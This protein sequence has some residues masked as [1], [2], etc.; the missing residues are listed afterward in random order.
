MKEARYKLISILLVLCITFTSLSEVLA[1]SA[2]GAPW[3]QEKGKYYGKQLAQKDKVKTING[4]SSKTSKPIRKPISKDRKPAFEFSFKGKQEVKEKRT[5]NSKTFKEDN[6]KLKTYVYLD[7][8]HYKDSSGKYQDID[9]TLVQQGKDD[10]AAYENKAN[11]YKV[12]FPSKITKNNSI[13][14]T[15]EDNSIQ[16]TPTEGDFS[17]S[18]VNGSSILYQDAF[19]GIDFQYDVNNSSV[20]EN[21]T[22]N[23]F[24]DKN[25]FKYEIEAKNLSLKEELGSI[26]AYKSGQKAP[27]FIINAP[28]MIDASGKK[29]SALKIHLNKKLIGKDIIEVEADKNWL[30]D[31][32][33]AYPVVID[34]DVSVPDSDIHTACTEQATPD[35]NTLDNGFLYV[36][37]DDGIATYNGVYGHLKTRTYIKFPLNADSTTKITSANLILDKYTSYSSEARSIGLY[38][39]DDDNFSIYEV[40][41]N[42]QPTAKSHYSSTTVDGTIKPAVFDVTNLLNDWINGSKHNNGIVLQY[43]DETKQCEVFAGMN[44]EFDSTLPHLEIESQIVDPVDPNMALGAPTI[45]VRPITEHNNDG[46]LKLD[47]VFADGVEKPGATVTYQSNPD[48]MKFNG[49]VNADKSYKYPDST[50]LQS[51]Y[52][53]GYVFKGKDSNWQTDKAVL[54][55][56]NKLYT[57]TATAQLDGKTT[58]VANSDSFQVYQVQAKDIFSSIANYYGVDLN[59]LLNDNKAEDGLLVEENT[60]FIR[61]PKNNGGKAYTQSQLTDEMKKQ[62]DSYLVGRK[63]HCIYGGEPINLISGN[64]YYNSDDVTVPDLGGNFTIS[65]SYNSMEDYHDGLFGVKWD[66]NFNK[67]LSQLKDGTIILNTGDGSAVYFTKNSDGSY[68]APAGVNDQLSKVSSTDGTSYQIIENEKITYKFYKNGLLKSITDIKGNVTQLGY[69]ENHKLTSITTPSEKQFVIKCDDQGRIA[70]IIQPNGAALSYGYD[71]KGNLTSFIDASGRETNYTYDDNNRMVSFNDGNHNQVISNT[72]DDQGRVLK[73][74]DANGSTV[75]I[76]YLDGYN[77][78]VDGNGN[79]TLYYYDS[80]YRTTKVVRPDKKTEESTYDDNDNLT[81]FKDAKDRITKYEYDERGNKLRETR[82]DEKS[83]AYTYDNQ[84]NLLSYT[85]FNGKTT[86]MT[87]DSVGNLIKV[88]NPDGAAV[89]YT[90]NSKN[91]VETMKDYQNNI[92]KYEYTGADITTVTEPNGD[93]YKYHYNSMG[94]VVTIEDPLNKISRI[95]YNPSGD[96]IN[97]QLPDNSVKEYDYDNNGNNKSMT[98]GNNNTISFQY[99]KLNKL[100]KAIDPLGYETKFIYDANG[101]KVVESN[102]RGYSKKYKYNNLNSLVGIT[103]EDNGTT[104]YVRDELGNITSV[105]DANGNKTTIVYNYNVN[106]P[107]SITNQL[108]QVITNIYDNEG[109]TLKT[110][111]PDGTYKQYSYD[112][113]YRLTKFKDAN[114]IERTITYGTKNKITKITDSTGK[115]YEY[116]YDGNGNLLKT[117]DPLGYNISYTYN[118]G[119]LMTS[120]TNEEGKTINYNYD[121]VGRISQIINPLG[122]KKSFN[123]DLNGNIATVTDG[124][125]YSTKYYYDQMNRLKAVK[126]ALEDIT[127]YN[128]D[129]V[130][131]IQQ[132][133]DALGNTTKYEYNGRNLTTKKTDALN[134]ITQ[135]IYD[136]DGNNIQ[137][138]DPKGSSYNFSYDGANRLTAV[139]DAAGLKKTTSYDNMNRV[140]KETDNAGNSIENSYDSYGRLTQQKDII[141]RT[142]K[143]E[144]DSSGNIV[145]KI[146]ID[147]NTTSYKYDA[148]NR[149][150]QV[151]DPEGKVTNFKYNG[152][153]KIVSRVEP[154][155]KAYSFEYDAGGNIVKATDPV[156]AATTFQYDGNNNLIEE[157]NAKGFSKKYKYDPIG[158]LNAISDENGNKTE[159]S[160]DGDRNVIKKV[161]PMGN[162]TQYL[163]DALNRLQTEVDALGFGKEYGY[164]KLGNMISFTDA[165]GNQTKYE[166]NNHNKVIK[167]TDALS[168]ITQYQYNLNDNILSKTDAIGAQYKYGYDAVHRLTT[169]TD[170]NGYIVN[171]NYDNLGNIDK[172]YDSAGN[173]K[174]FT[175]DKMHRLLTEKDTAGHMTT[176]NYDTYGNI[177][178]VKQPNGNVTNYEHDILNRLT[179]IVDPEGKTTQINYDILGNTEKVTNPGDQVYQYNYDPAN[180]LQS[181]TNPLGETT[182]YGYNKN[183][184]LESV[185]NPLGNTT[186]YSYNEINKLKEIKNPLGYTTIYGYDE[187][188]NLASV[189][190]G[191]GQRSNYNYDKLNRLS[192]VTNALGNATNYSYD[193][194]GNL[195]N[196]TDG[197]GHKTQYTYDKR[198]AL[199]SIKNPLEQTESFTYNDIGNVTS[200]T[201][202]DGTV[203]NYSYDNLNRL[204][205]TDTYNEDSESA[206]SSSDS[207]DSSD[208][209][210]DYSYDIMGNRT[211]MEGAEGVT[212]YTYDFMERLTNVNSPT[213]EEVKYEYDSLGRKSKLIYPDGKYVSYSYDNLNRLVSAV[214]WEGKKTTYTYDAG[215]RRIETDLPN[216]DKVKY[217]Y[218]EAD[219]LIKQENISKDGKTLSSFDYAYDKAG[220][221]VKEVQHDPDNDDIFT[222]TY[223]YDGA[224]EVIGFTEQEGTEEE[225]KYDYAYDKAGNRIA[226]QIKDDDDSKKITY[227]YDSA[228]QLITELDGDKNIKYEY[229]KNGNRIKKIF[230]GNHVEYYDYDLEGRLS[231]ITHVSGSIETFGYDGDGNRLF[232]TIGYYLEPPANGDGSTNGVESETNKGEKG[233]GSGSDSGN[234]KDKGNHNG[235]NSGKNS[236]KSSLLGNPRLAE[237]QQIK[238]LLAEVK[239]EADS[240]SESYI[241]SSSIRNPKL[242]EQQRIKD[243]IAASKSG[244]GGG[245]HSS[246]GGSNSH[247]GGNSGKS[248]KGNG[249]NG[250]GS[251]QDN[252]NG[253]D[254]GNHYG[255]NKK[256]TKKIRGGNGK[257]LGWYKRAQKPKLHGKSPIVTNDGTYEVVNYLNDVSLANPEVLMTSDE[258]KVYQSA[259]TYGLDRISVRYLAGNNDPKYTPLYYHYNGR[260]DVTSLVNTADNTKAK[261]RY[262]AFGV[263]KPGVKL[264]IDSNG[265]IN[266]YGYNSEDYDMY[267]GIQYLRARY[268]EP[269]TGRFLTRDSYLG[270]IMN[271]LTL[272]RYAYVGNNP[273][274][275]TDP[276]GNMFEWLFSK[277]DTSGYGYVDWKAGYSGP[278]FESTSEPESETRSYDTPIIYGY[279]DWKAGGSGLVFESTSEPESETQSYDTSITSSY[280]YSNEGTYQSE[281]NNNQSFIDIV[282]ERRK[283]WEKECG[284]FSYMNSSE[285]T[286]NADT[287]GSQGPSNSTIIFPKNAYPGYYDV[288]TRYDPVIEMYKD[289]D[290]VS[291]AIFQ[292]PFGDVINAITIERGGAFVQAVQKL[293]MAEEEAAIIT[294]EVGITSKEA[295]NLLPEGVGAQKNHNIDPDSYT[296]GTYDEGVSN[297]K[298]K[299]WH[300]NYVDN[301]SETQ[302]ILGVENVDKG[303][304]TIGSATESV[305]TNTGKAWVGEGYKAITDNAGNVIGYSSSDGMR[306]FRIQY[307]PKE[308]MWRANF[309][310]NYKYINE[311]GATKIKELKNVHIDILD[312]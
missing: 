196:F 288:S 69:D 3:K 145:S 30:S 46:L 134:N 51:T 61:N 307:K 198:G 83:R 67:Y 228:D 245:G 122:N 202:P 238:G 9:N 243:Y 35:I 188:R 296:I 305:A 73:Q 41:W 167:I 250:N 285:G 264:D 208:D 289:A 173:V 265:F 295:G 114:G 24:T 302:T 199:T 312:K 204:V 88:V 155:E 212:D 84:N 172:Q 239:F 40:N 156:N 13:Q 106:K 72:Y 71:D 249:R 7:K 92:T 147:G 164:D 16:L 244:G 93:T 28:V 121:D 263:P 161:D 232:R 304:A 159:F 148:R 132:K 219:Q 213:D 200:D 236:K 269:G 203:T 282:N 303:L 80:Q 20:K 220:N 171:F 85:D 66:F 105:T 258:N 60:I 18:A 297:P 115:T 293:K 135:Y 26:R 100:V 292:Q 44:N 310:E 294:D 112:G 124:N 272:N 226:V 174:N 123:Y 192:N 98:D 57:I 143:F 96:L 49:T 185:T 247:S 248:S 166:Y 306:A 234:G 133:V 50:P 230:P 221:I 99:D 74:Q 175:Y 21:I 45:N 299:W 136:G 160:Y 103:N 276:S 235:E 231:Q 38:N 90:Y 215:G 233:K 23:H 165:K 91:Q 110:T 107:E 15:K 39:I 257:H 54:P 17:R 180:N 65:R 266:P 201:K 229:D 120:M 75:S 152:L 154:G 104:S 59:T 62:I 137:I 287:S 191:N 141:G 184:Q 151:T 150:T 240:S 89:E 237:L 280:N 291:E 195:T 268:Y 209:E 241:D 277:S 119:N 216:G 162:T 158:M 225:K 275:R 19:N 311:Q 273:L 63:K 177:A 308:G 281:I 246:G 10:A 298:S 309:T 267:S 76:S 256:K 251:G 4:E 163:Y 178:S 77:Q 179:K 113:L 153:N 279:D 144:Y 286:S 70:S 284:G 181:V 128:Y 130:G 170:P 86:T 131:N 118:L 87:Y 101:N 48:D 127:Q 182:K 14:I 278:V 210:V 31:K 190:D 253:K 42:N 36:G 140:V 37:Y 55:D 187:N 109:N 211:S 43:D 95:A 206:D 33:R 259:Y 94:K 11:D 139:T 138:I 242:I 129:S 82:W 255:Q 290:K 47:A 207:S 79:T 183:N 270:N 194:V 301:L 27:V 29:S 102:P 223:T 34:P 108:G 176:Y 58:D 125:G 262:E 68:S 52:P 126:D 78:V 64:F 271:P 193:G 5:L 214:D 222:R 146:D 117:T 111:F 97:S 2:K 300:P 197:N 56:L 252:G 32:S 283:A 22:L 254:K 227:N 25:I 260:G 274:M 261:Y 142:K 81:S 224:N 189:T 149:I 8:V 169:I 168:G 53:N 186:T 205:S 116:S 1:L 12:S 157:K 6:K 217:T 218:N